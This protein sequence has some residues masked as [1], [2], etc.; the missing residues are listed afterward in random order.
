MAVQVNVIVHT[1]CKLLDC[2]CPI[3]IVVVANSVIRNHECYIDI[4][5]L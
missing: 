4:V 5:K 2:C 3:Q 1:W